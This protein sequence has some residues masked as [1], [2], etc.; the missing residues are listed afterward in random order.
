MIIRD[1]ETG[2][3]YEVSVHSVE[4]RTLLLRELTAAE[5]AALNPPAWQNEEY[6]DI[7]LEA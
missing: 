7:A 3:L 1:H 6:Y 2:A 5:A 4:A